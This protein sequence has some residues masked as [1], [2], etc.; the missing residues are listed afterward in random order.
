MLNF[1]PVVAA[2]QYMSDECPEDIT[3]VIKRADQFYEEHS[4]KK[5]RDLLLK[6]KNVDNA[7][8][9][10]RLARAEY[11]M[12]KLAS[13]Y[14][15]QKHLNLEAYSYVER[16]LALDGNNFAVHKWMFILL[17]KK[18]S[19][20]GIKERISQS[21]IVKRHIEKACELNP[22]DPTSFHLLGYYCFAVSQLPWYQRQIASTLFATP[23]TSS[24][25]EALTY[26]LKAEEI[27][28]NFYRW[29]KGLQYISQLLRIIS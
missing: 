2:A 24:Y 1:I 25:E 22:S 13:S 28:P 17:D 4:Y 15:E 14:I 12:A 19:Y 3:E 27:E 21:F 9:L 20:E 29:E 10:W 5:L 7:E 18:S 26:F 11:E 8:I 23:P 16:A 6:Y